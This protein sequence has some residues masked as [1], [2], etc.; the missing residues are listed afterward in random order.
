MRFFLV[1]KLVNVYLH[2]VEIVS[3][4]QHPALFSTDKNQYI[5]II[6]LLF[7]QTLISPYLDHNL[8]VGMY[9]TNK[10]LIIDV[11]IFPHLPNSK[12]IRIIYN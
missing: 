4:L 2:R 7:C 12:S 9:N 8:S 5:T 6:Y 1:S 3:S 10:R 11:F